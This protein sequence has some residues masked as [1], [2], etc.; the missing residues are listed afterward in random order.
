MNKIIFT[1][2]IGV[3]LITGCA[4]IKVNV[5]P[6]GS[7][8]AKGWS[9]WKEIELP[10]VVIKTGTNSTVEVN[11]WKSTN[12]ASKEAVSNLIDALEKYVK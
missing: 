1:F 7:W 6:D 11:G 12:N 3:L 2:L 9:F 10:R 5:E 8:E 4:N